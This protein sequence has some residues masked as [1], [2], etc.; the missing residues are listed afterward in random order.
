MAGAAGDERDPR[1]AREPGPAVRHMCGGRFMTH[2]DEA[3]A[4]P[5][6]HAQNIVQMIPDERKQVSNAE[7]PESGNEELRPARHAVD[8]RMRRSISS[9]SRGSA[10]LN[11]F[12]PVSVT[13]TMS[14]IRI[15]IFSSGM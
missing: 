1:L 5:V 15:P 13:S 14:S 3:E 8:Y 6:S 2:I 10:A 7:L 9:A 4:L 11:T 12:A